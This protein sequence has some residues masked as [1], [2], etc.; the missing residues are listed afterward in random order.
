MF[1]KVTPV[2]HYVVLC[3]EIN[4][5]PGGGGS[6]TPQ[7]ILAFLCTVFFLYFV[8]CILLCIMWNLCIIVCLA[9]LA[10]F[11]QDQFE[12]CQNDF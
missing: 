6:G 7:V 5:K 1:C 10:Q 2:I 9:H 4:L 8:L 3:A 12:Q 11:E